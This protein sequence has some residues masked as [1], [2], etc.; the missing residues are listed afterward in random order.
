MKKLFCGVVVAALALLTIFAAD[1]PK[2]GFKIVTTN[3]V[4]E[5]IFTNM[6]AKTFVFWG[7][8]GGHTNNT[9]IV[10]IQFAATSSSGGFPVYPGQM[11]KIT[12]DTVRARQMD[13]YAGVDTS[14]DG[15]VWQLFQ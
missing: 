13:F 12:V 14:G 2:E 8:K 10:W 11:L 5:L 7:R 9:G 1:N 15:V 6:S 3:T 4:P